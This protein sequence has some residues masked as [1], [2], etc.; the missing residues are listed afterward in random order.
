[1]A[2]Q[3]HEKGKK[4][5]ES[6]ASTAV[7]FEELLLTVNLIKKYCRY[8]HHKIT[9]NIDPNADLMVEEEKEYKERQ[10]SKPSSTFLVVDSLLPLPPLS[11]QAGPS[12]QPT[13]EVPQ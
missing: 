2:I 12:K 5:E 7:E 9:K 10:K 13:Q 6:P 4:K 11:E 1:M 3:G 8:L